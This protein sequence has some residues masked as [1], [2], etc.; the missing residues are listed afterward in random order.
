VSGKILAAGDRLFQDESAVRAM[1][2]F[3]ESVARR[4][5]RM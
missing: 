1:E 5:S 2:E 3:F 4:Q